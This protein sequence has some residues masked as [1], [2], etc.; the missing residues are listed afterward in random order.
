MIHW[1]F[2]EWIYH[3]PSTSNNITKI[4]KDTSHIYMEENIQIVAKDSRYS[5]AVITKK[6]LKNIRN[7]YPSKSHYMEG[8][9]RELYKRGHL[10]S[11]VKIVLL[12]YQELKDIQDFAQDFTNAPF[13]FGQVE[14]HILAEHYGEF[15]T[16]HLFLY[17][18]DQQLI[19]ELKG[20]NRVVHLKKYFEKITR[21]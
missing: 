14:L 4:R 12:S 6:A 7:N 21:E 1:W 8:F 15:S 3:L 18:K 17:N 13:T 2:Y 16:P 9:Y 10:L 11:K 20:I 5:V 19:K